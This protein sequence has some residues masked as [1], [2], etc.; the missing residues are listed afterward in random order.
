MRASTVFLIAA[1]IVLVVGCSSEKKNAG[2]YELEEYIASIRESGMSESAQSTVGMV[3]SHLAG[4][5]S[6]TYQSGGD[7]GRYWPSYSS[8][9][10][11]NPNLTSEEQEAFSHKVRGEQDQIV[12]KIRHLADLDNS[13][14]ITTAEAA[15]FRSIYEFGCLAKFV[16][17][18]VEPTAEAIS[19][20]TG[21]SEDALAAKISAY[22][23]LC[24]GASSQDVGGFEVLSIQ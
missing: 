23:D 1:A 15:K 2:S 6:I 17:S 16:C 5:I 19:Q 9:T 20:A 12:A 24:E 4:H 22:N 21:I 10:C 8:N 18:E 7:S 3:A 13:G 11:P 14:F